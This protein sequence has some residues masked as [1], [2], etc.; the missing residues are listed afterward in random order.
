MLLIEFLPKTPLFQP[1]WCSFLSCCFSLHIFIIIKVSQ[2]LTLSVRTAWKPHPLINQSLWLW[3]FMWGGVSFVHIEIDH[4]RI[5][6]KIRNN[7]PLNK[8]TVSSFPMCVLLIDV[9]WSMTLL[10]ASVWGKA[11]PTDRCAHTNTALSYSSRNSDHV[12]SHYMFQFFI[13]LNIHFWHKIPE[14]LYSK[15]ECVI[16]EVCNELSRLQLSHLTCH[17]T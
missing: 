5:I 11:K 6:M 8:L 14:S 16:W 7:S 2:S 1:D 10:L 4:L 9:V 13:W 15:P 17:H 3:L 12:I